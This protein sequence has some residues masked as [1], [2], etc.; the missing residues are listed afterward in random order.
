MKTRYWALI[1]AFI[2]QLLY[3]LNFTFAK[4]VLSGGFIKP[5]GFIVIRVA[6]AT[7]LFW[8]FS[9][10]GPKEKIDK[11]DYWTFFYAAIFGVALNMLLFFKGL[12]FTSPIHASVIMITAPIIA[13][14]TPS[15]VPPYCQSQTFCC[16]P[17][18]SYLFHVYFCFHRNHR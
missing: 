17:C 9:F 5:S 11:K 1:A 8:I 14:H 4:D 3:G 12:A 15:S 10:L 13:Y 2:V 16:H 18:L 7:V 6:G